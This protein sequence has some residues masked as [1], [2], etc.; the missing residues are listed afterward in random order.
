MFS[1]KAMYQLRE[2]LFDKLDSFGISCTENQKL[3][4]NMAIPNFESICVED[5]ILKK[6][7]T[8]TWIQ[9]HNPISV[10]ISS[11]LTQKSIFFCESNRCDLV[12]PF[13]NG[14]EYLARQS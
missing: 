11:N 2:T 1:Q 14:L 7:E 5:E 9:K 10:S 4:T 6:T 8:T 3:F 13:K 12:T